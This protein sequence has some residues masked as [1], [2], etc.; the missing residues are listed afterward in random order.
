V[1]ERG[2]EIKCHTHVYEILKEGKKAVG[3]RTNH[4][5]FYAD[6]IVDAAGSLSA[7]LGNA[8]GLYVPVK[9]RRGQVMVTEGL[10]HILSG[11][12]SSASFF[13]AKFHPELMQLFDPRTVKLNYGTALEQTNTG[14]MLIGATNEWTGY[15]NGTTIEGIEWVIHE[16][17]RVLPYL[18]NA[19]FIRTFSGLRPSTP[20]HLPIVGATSHLENY[21]LITGF[22]GG[23]ISLNPIVGKMLAEI[24]CGDEPCI[25]N[26]PLRPDRIVK[27]LSEA[28]AEEIAANLPEGV[29]R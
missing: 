20:D 27:P 11:V 29:V 17:C 18:R 19:H 1:E 7:Q 5:D 28:T 12:V 16:A 22:E 15:D 14:T 9:P 24:I 3:V 2:G 13:C 23:G 26:E 10:P 8:A 25:T 6:A 4:G 21:Y